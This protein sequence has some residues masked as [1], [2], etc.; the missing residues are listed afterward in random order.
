MSP[1]R[2]IFLN[3]AA[4]YGRSLFGIACGLFS[5]RWVLMALG[6]TDL[7][8]YGLVG[9][10]AL[11]VTFFNIQFSLAISRYFAYS[12]GQAKA[13]EDKSA[14]LEECRRWFNSR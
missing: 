13:S 3:I 7:G 9:G 4:S 8:L 14:G 6:K 12:I 2:R 10:L 11:F 5:T 1:N